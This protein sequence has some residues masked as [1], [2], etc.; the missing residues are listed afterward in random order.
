MFLTCDWKSEGKGI[1]GELI[2]ATSWTQ[3]REGWKEDREIT[4]QG[5]IWCLNLGSLTLEPGL[6]IK[7]SITSHMKTLKSYWLPH[8]SGEFLY[9]SGLLKR[10]SRLQQQ[11]PGAQPPW[12]G[13]KRVTTTTE[14]PQ[15]CCFPSRPLPRIH[16]ATWFADIRQLKQ[17]PASRHHAGSTMAC[18]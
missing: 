9:L 14:V 1:S 16:R 5:K 6:L 4:N 18:E 3:G 11:E 2:K 13:A 10:A 17:S 7:Y 15:T 12:D 8:S